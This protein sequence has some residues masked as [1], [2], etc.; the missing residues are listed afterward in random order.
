MYYIYDYLNIDNTVYTKR[1]DRECCVNGA[2]TL[3]LHST[4]CENSYI[5][6]L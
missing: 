1:D 5:F 3:Y 2:L 6:V 4:H